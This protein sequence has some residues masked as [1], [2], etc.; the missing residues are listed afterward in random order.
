MALGTVGVSV[1]VLAA[2]DVAVEEMVIGTKLVEVEGTILEAVVTE[3]TVL[4]GGR[5][6][7]RSV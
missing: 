4:A 7:K 5:E 3:E 2:S 1:I 6:A